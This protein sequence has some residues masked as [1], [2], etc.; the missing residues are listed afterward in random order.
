MASPAATS[1]RKTPLARL[2]WT[3]SCFSAAMSPAETVLSAVTTTLPEAASVYHAMPLTP[4]RSTAARAAD[5]RAPCDGAAA[6]AA[7]TAYKHAATAVTAA[8]SCVVRRRRRRTDVRSILTDSSRDVSGTLGGIP[9]TV[10]RLRHV[11]V[12]TPAD[13]QEYLPVRG[14]GQPLSSPRPRGAYAHR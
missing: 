13:T 1:G 14:Y 11:A 9:R 6:F 4:D 10:D 2:T 7:G 8:R 3:A 12:A 5:N